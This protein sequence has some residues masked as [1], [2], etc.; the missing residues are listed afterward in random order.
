[1][2]SPEVLPDRRITW[3]LM[4]PQAQSVRL[5]GADFTGAIRGGPM[6][7]GTNGIWEMTLGPLEPGAY[8]YN[9]NVDGVEVNDP[10]NP[11]TS[12]SNDHAWSM[13]AVPG[14]D[15]T[16]I[17][18]VPHGAVAEVHYYSTTLKRFRRMQI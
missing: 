4:A 1:M 17:R 2:V 15:L 13:V 9:F 3:C 11:T 10:R 5:T 12:E 8:R 16:D 18:D 6:T 7:K 14:S